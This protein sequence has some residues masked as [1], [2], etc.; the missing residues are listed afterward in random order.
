MTDKIE[1]QFAILNTKI[2]E[3]WGEK[4]LDTLNRM[5]RHGIQMLDEPE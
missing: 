2:N 4:Y 1:G 5:A 3:A